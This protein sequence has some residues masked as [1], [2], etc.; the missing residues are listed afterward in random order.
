M[1][2]LETLFMLV[3]M[4]NVVAT[5]VL[6]TYSKLLKTNTCTEMFMGAFR[7]KRWKQ[8][9]CP[10]TDKWQNAKIVHWNIFRP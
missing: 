3:V 2:K 8:P 9:K 7:A 1:E 6:V 5:P 4:Q 10:S